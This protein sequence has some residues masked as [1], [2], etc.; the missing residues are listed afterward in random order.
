MSKLQYEKPAYQKLIDEIEVMLQGQDSG[1]VLTALTVLVGNAG[2]WHNMDFEQ[3]IDY[4]ERNTCLVYIDHKK[5]E[6]L[7][8]LH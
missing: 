1:V 7:F 2:Y 6:E 5:E 8:V 4:V 3:F